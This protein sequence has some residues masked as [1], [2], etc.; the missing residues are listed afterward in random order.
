MTKKNAIPE[1]S[2]LIEHAR[3]IVFKARREGTLDSLTVNGVKKQLELHWS[4]DGGTLN[5]GEYKKAIGDAVRNA[6]TA[7]IPGSDVKSELKVKEVKEQKVDKQ[8]SEDKP[9]STTISSNQKTTNAPVTSPVAETSRSASAGVKKV[10][11]MPPPEDRGRRD[12]AL[13]ITKTI[14]K[15]NERP[16]SNSNSVT[17]LKR[18][19]RSREY[20]EDD[21]ED[22]SAITD[23]SG[24]GGKP[25]SEGSSESEEPERSRKRRKRSI[26]EVIQKSSRKRST[27]KDDNDP[28]ISETDEATIKQL[29]AYV[30]ACGVRKKW[31]KEFQN[32]PQP[33]QQIRRLKKILADLG[34]EGK[35]SM[36]KAKQ[37][38]KKRDLARE[39]EDVIEFE[40][41]AGV[42]RSRR[43]KSG[44]PVGELDTET[45]GEDDSN[46]S[47]SDGERRRPAS[48]VIKKY[49]KKQTVDDSG[50]E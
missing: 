39:L 18:P 30:G 50:E 29:K 5:T 24:N 11:K 45:E 23:S 7:E 14:V 17:S 27:G 1:L 38:K 8:P 43:K 2:K 32:Y 13:N 20:I 41:K 31:A 37:I 44:R 3:N 25:S 10:S 34:M 49:L 19:F 15:T 6:V 26:Q 16:R 47:D 40:R 33:D 48:A 4:L 42:S 35:Y 22:D 12:F 9:T 28:K 36:E 21:D 46:E